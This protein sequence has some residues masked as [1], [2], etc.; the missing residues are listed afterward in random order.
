MNKWHWARHGRE[1]RL[2]DQ[3][4]KTILRSTG[5]E[6]HMECYSCQEEVRGGHPETWLLNSDGDLD[7][8][9]S[10]AKLLAL[11]PEMLAHLELLLCSEAD[12]DDLRN[13]I[14]RITERAHG[15]AT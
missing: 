9:S 6:V 7:P 10:D 12:D 3:D 13:S 1:W 4:G 15:R 2:E 14:R 8:E 11:A 5:H